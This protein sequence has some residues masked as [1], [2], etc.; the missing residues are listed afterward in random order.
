MNNNRLLDYIE[1]ILEATRLAVSYIDGME[2]DGFLSDKRTQHAVILNIVVI[3]E[4]ATKIINNYPDFIEQ[5][6]DIPWK[7]MKGMRNRVA[8]GYFDI[9]L[10]IVWNTVQTALPNLVEK[11]KPIHDKMVT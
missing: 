6:P 4:A 2:E 8:H 10:E 5:H 7:S 1:H 11:L 3:G 9:N